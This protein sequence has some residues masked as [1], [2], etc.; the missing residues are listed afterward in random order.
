[1]VCFEQQPR[2]KM[3]YRIFPTRCQEQGETMNLHSTRVRWRKTIGFIQSQITFDKTSIVG[4]VIWMVCILYS[5][6]KSAQKVSEVTMPDVEKPGTFYRFN[7]FFFVCGTES[8]RMSSATGPAIS[9]SR[10]FQSSPFSW[11]ENGISDVRVFA[12]VFH[13]FFFC[14]FQLNSPVLTERLD[15]QD[16]SKPITASDVDTKVWDNE[17]D[18]VAYSWSLFHV[19][20]I[21]ATLYIMMTLTNWYQ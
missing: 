4:L 7:F 16:S 19:V 20:F 15:G 10:W 8:T 9:F 5:S 21:V 6:L 13:P 1:M 14:S 2:R 17:G 18:G 12:P 3:P 11:F